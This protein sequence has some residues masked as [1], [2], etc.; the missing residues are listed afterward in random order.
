MAS[1]RGLDWK[2]GAAR[3]LRPLLRDAAV[4]SWLFNAHSKFGS[5]KYTPLPFGRTT[6]SSSNSNSRLGPTTGAGVT[7]L[8]RF[9]LPGLRGE[10][11]VLLQGWS[12]AG[13]DPDKYSI[14][15]TSTTLEILTPARPDDS[16][17]SEDSTLRTPNHLS[18]VSRAS[19][20]LT[21]TTS[22][23]FLRSAKV[24]S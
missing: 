21:T 11:V 15:L 8:F 7:L 9:P 5:S 6:D 16:P 10:I 23:A 24:A 12:R 3:R 17:T 14:C 2:T 13:T 4:F 1:Y 22:Y 19:F 20:R 18:D